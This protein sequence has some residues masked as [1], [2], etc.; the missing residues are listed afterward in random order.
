MEVEK[1]VERERGGA[2]DR[3][4]ADA[5]GSH[6]QIHTPAVGCMMVQTCADHKQGGGGGW[7]INTVVSHILL[8]EE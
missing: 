1:E 2:D 6:S 4:A 8:Y 5:A 3:H 7:Y